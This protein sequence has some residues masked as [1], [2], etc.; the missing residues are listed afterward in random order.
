MHSYSFDLGLLISPSSLT[1]PF[2]DL[3]VGKSVS[4]GAAI[5]NIGPSIHWIDEARQD[6]LPTELRLGLAARA[7]KGGPHRLT[8]TFDIGKPLISRTLQ[9]NGVEKADPFFTALFKSWHENPD[10]SAK[11][12]DDLLRE[13]LFGFGFEYVYDGFAALRIGY[14]YSFPRPDDRRRI[15]IGLGLQNEGIGIDASCSFVRVEDSALDDPLLRLSLS[16]SWDRDSGMEAKRGD[17]KDQE[18]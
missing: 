2:T 11:S 14:V 17:L 15:S 1:I 7:L 16:V 6:P 9:P 13:M 18:I 5:R 8:W 4:F 12:F 3:D 10:G